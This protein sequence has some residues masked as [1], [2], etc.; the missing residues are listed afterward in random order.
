[1]ADW[2]WI[3]KDEVM[4]L[5]ERQLLIHG[6]LPG[7]RDEDLLESAVAKP[8]NIFAYGEPDIADLAAAYAFRLSRNRSFM[9]GNKRA[10]FVTCA[11]FLRLNVYRLPIERAV[12]I[13]TWLALASGTLGEEDLA[14]WLRAR[15]RPPGR[16]WGRPDLA[17][18]PA[19]A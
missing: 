17:F 18:R 4:I 19:A 6:G 9:D 5:H 3:T 15:I 7:L 11:A 1:M 10:S 14:A 2:R 12:N 13:E 16:S 8:R